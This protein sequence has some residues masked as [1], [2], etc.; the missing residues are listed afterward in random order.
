MTPVTEFHYMKAGLLV[1]WG[2]RCGHLSNPMWYRDAAT[3]ELLRSTYETEPCWECRN[4]TPA[5]EPAGQS[6]R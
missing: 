1:S 5:C 3:A 4:A 2:H 6:L